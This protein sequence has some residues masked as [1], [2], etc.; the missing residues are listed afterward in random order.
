MPNRKT[1]LSKSVNNA[2]PKTSAVVAQ[3]RQ[4]PIPSPEDMRGYKLVDAD[5]PNR[6][7][8]MAENEQNTQYSLRSKIID[9]RE[10]MSRRDFISDMAALGT[11]TFL[12]TCMI[13]AA[14]VMFYCDKTGAGIFF[15]ATALISLPKTFL[16]PRKNNT[17]KSS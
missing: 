17:N 1:P 11:C 12:C 14:S 5:L 8:T 3:L 10:N 15:T 9:N 7:M 2:F 6:I 4:G 13:I 16:W